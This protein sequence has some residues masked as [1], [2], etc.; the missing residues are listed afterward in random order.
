MQPFSRTAL[1]VLAAVFWTAVFM[2][3][4]RAAAVIPVPFTPQAPWGDWSQPYQDFCEE[5]SSVMAAHFLWGVGITPA[6]ADL[7]MRIILQY[8]ELVFGR[9]RDTSVDETAMV[10][11]TLYGFRS[12]T[13]ALVSSP[14]DIKSILADGHPVIAPVAGHL[15]KNP[16]FA[17]SDPFY[18]MLVVRGFDERNRT[19]IT[20][21]PGTRRGEG[22]AYGERLL[23]DA[24][25]DWNR[26]DFMRGAKR[27]LI[28]KR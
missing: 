23:F 20:N 28:V 14:D 11:R 17:G 26:S 18:H 8:E 10:L 1:C 13:T 4:A 7:E 24:I 25:R 15:L 21:D 5:A 12:V 6:I 2:P 27:V 22:F 3:A 9:S 16:Y 19:F